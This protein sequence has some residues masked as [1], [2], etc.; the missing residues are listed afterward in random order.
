MVICLLQIPFAVANTLT[1]R[2]V[3]KEAI[4]N[5]ATTEGVKKKEA[6]KINLVYFQFWWSLFLL[7]TVIAF[8]WTDIIPHFGTSSSWHEFI[9]K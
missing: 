7:L 9:E 6:S 4:S 8:F 1:E 3:Q 5:P 2:S